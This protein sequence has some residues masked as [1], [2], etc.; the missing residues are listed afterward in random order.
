MKYCFVKKILTIILLTPLLCMGQW[1]VSIETD[2]TTYS[3]ECETLL[4]AERYAVG[5]IEFQSGMKA[6]G[7]VND[8]PFMRL[9]HIVYFFNDRGRKMNY[10][11]ESKF[12]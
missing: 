6:K 1:I 10:Y 5:E 3:R 8:T 7:S 11:I 9:A 4:E 2:D 12:E